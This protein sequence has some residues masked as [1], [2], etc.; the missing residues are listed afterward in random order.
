MRVRLTAV[1]AIAIATLTMPVMAQVF[2]DKP[3]RF[4]V[5]QAAGTAS[6]VLARLFVPKWSEL[7]G[8]P[9][10]VDN[11]AGAGGIIGT[12]V[13]AKSAPDGYTILLGTSQTFATN[14][15]LYKKLSYDP[16][17]DFAPVG[18]IAG[19]PMVFV[20]NAVMPAKTFPEFM[21][22]AKTA[23]RLNFASSGNGS[24]AH[25]AGALF[26]AETGLKAE[27]VPYKA[28]PQAFTDL[29]SGEMTMMFYPYNALQ[30]HIQSGRVIPLAVATEKRVAFLPQLPTFAEL[31]YPGMHVSPWLAIYAPAKTPRRV[32][33]ILYSTLEKAL[34]DPDV[35]RRIEQTGTDIYLAN[36]DELGKFTASEI[37]RFRDIVKM[38]GATPE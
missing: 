31:G 6:D 13:V 36:P 10:I 34:S 16:I 33:D 21:T 5:P 15:S 7:L 35:V 28:V 26:N 29:L 25:L 24:A 19:I 8:Q 3:I 2:P 20:I 12:E 30:T 32:I 17:A 37:A 38:S 1:L 14:S 11:R 23:K 22:Y 9:I 27:H 4:I 18:R